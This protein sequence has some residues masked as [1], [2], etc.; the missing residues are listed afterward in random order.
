MLKLI[1][2]IRSSHIY[3]HENVSELPF[4]MVRPKYQWGVLCLV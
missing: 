3:I 2:D 4:P 1:L